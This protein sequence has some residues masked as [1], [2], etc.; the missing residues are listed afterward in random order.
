MSRSTETLP[1]RLH[2]ITWAAQDICLFELRPL[3]GGSLPAYTAGAHI[4]VLLPNG[5][6]RSYSLVNPPSDGQ[7]YVIAV[8][9]DPASRGGSRYMH[10]RM[11]VGETVTIR[12]PQNDFV[13]I[14]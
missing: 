10:E 5:L 9:L 14:E 13:L 11:R 7:R 2:S 4:D 12:G 3:S 1:T 6:V 8:G